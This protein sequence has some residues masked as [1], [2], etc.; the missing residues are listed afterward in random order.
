MLLIPISGTISVRE[1]D[2]PPQALFT[3]TNLKWQALSC[4]VGNLEH[5]GVFSVEREVYTL[6]NLYNWT[7]NLSCCHYTGAQ[8]S[9]PV[10]RVICFLVFSSSRAP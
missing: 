1:N 2:F 10:P 9:H 8:Q 6:L 5:A 4:L 7:L 3:H